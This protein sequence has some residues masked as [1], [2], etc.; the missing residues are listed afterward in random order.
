VGDV[1]FWVINRRRD[2]G[3]RV[4]LRGWLAALDDLVVPRLTVADEDVA[5]H[6]TDPP[7][8]YVFVSAIQVGFI[9]RGHF[10]EHYGSS[11]KTSVGSNSTS[12]TTTPQSPSGLGARVV[13]RTHPSSSRSPSSPSRETW[14][15]P[16]GRSG[17]HCP[18]D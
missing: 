2:L 1:E 5:L 4:G 15:T 14:T 3:A 17:M 12:R 7:N 13:E 8:P 6:D 18:P 11:V 9:R 16:S 10:Y